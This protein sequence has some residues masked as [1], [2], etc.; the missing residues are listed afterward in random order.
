M[1]VTSGVYMPL[2]DNLQSPLSS[3]PP[4]PLLPFNGYYNGHP[5]GYFDKPDSDI[6]DLNNELNSNA[7]KAL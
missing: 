6:D 7:I 3:P 1:D 4:S 2:S 5:D